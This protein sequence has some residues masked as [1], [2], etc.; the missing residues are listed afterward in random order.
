MDK[1]GIVKEKLKKMLGTRMTL[2]QYTPPVISD[3][4]KDM[5]FILWR[6]VVYFNFIFGYSHF[7]LIAKAK[8]IP[9]LLDYRCNLQ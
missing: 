9:T 6:G 2:A 4:E 7:K 8:K 3:R 5:T 1:S